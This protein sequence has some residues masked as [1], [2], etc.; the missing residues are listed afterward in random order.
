MSYESAVAVL[1]EHGQ[2]HVLV[3]WEQLNE[4]DRES[5]L[6]QVDS[7]D[8]AGVARMRSLL[9][10]GVSG[11]GGEL[12]PAPV[13][14][15]VGEDREVAVRAGE[16]AI[17]SG[18]V[19]VILVAG[20]QGSRLGYDGPKGCYEI[21]PITGASLF[22]I[23]SRKILALEKK[24]DAEVPFYV[25][26]SMVNDAS[27]KEFFAANGWFGLSEG[28]VMFFKQGMW[29]ALDND[30]RIVMDRP[31]HIFMSPDGH[32]GILSALAANDMLN[33]MEERGC[34]TLF[35][36]QVDNP[37]VEIADPVFIGIHR[38]E[39]ADIS[40]KVCAKRDPLEK[41]G[42]VVERDG[43]SAV[44]EYSELSDEQ[45]NATTPSGELLFRFGSVAIHVFSLAFLHEEAA[46]DLPLHVAHKKI[47][48][49]DDSGRTVHPDGPNACKFEKFVF[50]VLPDAN[51]VVNMEFAREDEFSPVKNAEGEDSPA[52]TRLDMQA[53]W[54]R[55]LRECGVAVPVDENGQSRF[56]IEIDPCFALGPDDLRE[57][58]PDGFVFNKD[59]MLS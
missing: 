52:S 6:A 32:G 55:W 35:Y 29:P 33:D 11:A 50:D 21:G 43:R 12:A 2:E 54:C 30:G 39:D 5:L 14:Y 53:K 8:F 25:M 10:N 57:R 19:G 56:L 44:V 24:Y 38:S 48:Y 45:M 3:F 51:R 20:G 16:D 46:A 58:L 27:T 7:L 34:E 31:D 40:V 28:R 41:L 1:A 47:P 17:R 23:H 26:T 9:T 18:L 13:V 37:L 4:Q 59:T 36:F 49:C 15:L 22:E 42:V